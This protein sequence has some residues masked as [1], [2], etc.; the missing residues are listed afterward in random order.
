MLVLTT[1]MLLHNSAKAQQNRGYI[2]ANQLLQQRN[3][4][5]AARQFEQLYQ[6]EPNRYLYLDKFTESLVNLKR[7]DQ[8]IEI[9]QQAIEQG[10]LD[11]QASIRLG[12][13]YHISGKSQKAIQIWEKVLREYKGDQQVY[14]RVAR[15]AKERKEFEKATEIFQKL[16]SQSGNSNIIISELGE[17]YLQAG[18]YEN[19]M[20]EFLELIRKTPDRLNYVQRRLMRFRDNYIYEVA[21]LE[22]SDFLDE[23]STEH[24]SYRQLQQLEI[25][26]LME[27]KLFER[28]VVTAKNI[29]EESSSLT[30]T[31]FN[32][33]SE[34]LAEQQFKLA[35]QAYSYY[36]SNEI[37]AV[38]T[39][40]REELANVYI[41]WAQ[42]LENHNL[43][44]SSKRSSLYQQAFTILETLHQNTPNYQ[45]IAQ[46]L[47]TLSELSLEVLHAPKKAEKY[48]SDLRNLSE[49]NRRPANEYHIEGRLLLYHGDYTRARI[50]L[51]KSNRQERI[52]DLAQKNRY[53]LALTDFFAGDYEFAK[54]QLN[55][56]ERQSTSYFAN[57]AVQLR[58]WIQQGL[59]ADSSGAKIKPFAELLEHL[60]RG[61]NDQAIA[62]VNRLFEQDSQ[63]PYISYA[64]LELDK[65]KN[66]EN[67]AF[68][69]QAV[70]ALLENRK[71]TSALHERLL[72]VKA[73]LADQIISND[74]QW[75]SLQDQPAQNTY[76]KDGDRN[77]P[78]SIS[79]L[80]EI[81][82]ELLMEFPN[83]FY[84]SFARDRIQELEEKQV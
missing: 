16:R 27:R 14:L 71:T 51:S 6:K 24:P 79:A 77:P 48:L 65:A 76:F 63:N 44:L 81:Y 12:E 10:R 37:S 50:S 34:L 57:D 15:T 46:V 33:G 41:E 64:L 83:G 20:K 23:L 84:A 61:N 21:I 80:I 72:W 47:T 31:L 19:A 45:R 22:I 69:Y 25:W 73:R 43:D 54:I 67:A 52:G 13:L 75:E 56:L 18:D 40:S 3:Y 8:A 9:T 17:T 78:T 49:N 66:N 62:T 60:S 29:E 39:Q 53:Y 11:P 35:E 28:A 30:Y 26:L 42:Y 4:E 68:L 32:L 38:S 7:Y 59:Q 58:L 74:I 82:E 1:G 36:I 70:D 55:A 2:Q 5:E